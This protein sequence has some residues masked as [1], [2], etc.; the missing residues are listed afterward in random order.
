VLSGEGL[1]TFTRN[2]TSGALTPAGLLQ[3]GF[4][5]VDGLSSPTFMT[6]SPDDKNVY[7][8]SDS[9]DESVAVFTRNPT[10]G[11]LTFDAVFKDGV[12]GVDG[13]NGATYVGI[14]PDGKSLYVTGGDENALAVFA[15]NT[16]TGALTFS[17]ALRDGVGGVDGLAGAKDVVVAPDGKMVYASGG[18]DDALTLFH[19]NT[20]TGALTFGSIIK[21]GTGGV[22]GLDGAFD[23]ELSPDGTNLYVTSTVDNAVAIFRRSATG[24]LTFA[25]ALKDGVGG[26]DGLGGGGEIALSPD[27]SNAYVAGGADDALAVF[28]RTPAVSPAPPAAYCHG[29]KAT[30]VGTGGD[31]VIIGTAKRD[32]IAGRGGHD[33]LRGRGGNDVI[34]GGSG[35]DIV[36]GGSGRDTL[37]GNRGNDRLS[38]GPADDRLF[39]GPGR[40]TLYGNGG[41]DRLV[42][43]KG[44]DQVSGG[45]GVDIVVG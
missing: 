39:G 4:G 8:T 23:I 18:S 45:A 17:N 41:D 19:R 37:Y 33:V 30:L 26:V 36:G 20:T 40:D 34:C 22:D 29:L 25:H 32:V 16:A 2:T 14:S 28:T 35:D 11:A 15:R 43:G 1:A 27:G 10:N 44:R 3:D 5:G 12:G 13:L 31:D 21:D 24:A 9:P 38:G 42:G 6:L 7:V